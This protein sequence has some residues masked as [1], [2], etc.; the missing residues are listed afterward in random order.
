ML[1]PEETVSHPNDVSGSNPETTEHE[2]E[3]SIQAAPEEDPKDLLIA[4]LTFERDQL[5]DQ[6]LRSVAELQTFRQRSQQQRL[7]LQKYGAEDLLQELLPV[8]DNFQRSLKAL[9]GNADPEAILQGV[10]M[11]ERQL[12][13]ALE[14][15]HLQRVVAVGEVFDPELHEAVGTV[16]TEEFEPNVIVDEVE[17]GYRLHERLLRPAKVRVA[18]RPQ[19]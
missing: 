16:E 3:E 13:T 17:A 14:S 11:V 7:E 2:A 8:L 9:E 10:S 1:N 5:R 12:R 6:L 4:A 15:A 19:A 18:T